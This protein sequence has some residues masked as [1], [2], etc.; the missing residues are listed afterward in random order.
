MRR[1]GKIR[2]RFLRPR[3]D[4]GCQLSGLTTGVPRLAFVAGPKPPG[5]SLPQLDRRHC[6]DARCQEVKAIPGRLSSISVTI[7]G[8]T[9]DAATRRTVLLH[10]LSF[11]AAVNG[12][13]AQDQWC[14]WQAVRGHSRLKRPAECVL[15]RIGCAIGPRRHSWSRFRV[16]GRR[17]PSMARIEISA[18]GARIC[19]PQVVCGDMHM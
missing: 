2:V 9:W 6:Q 17:K 16:R 5:L 15:R 1:L 14:L 11:A 19:V 4:M 8:F 7:A 18:R 12:C 3:T 10:E 13:I